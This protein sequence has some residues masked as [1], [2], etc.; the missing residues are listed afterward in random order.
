MAP[1]L[2][3]TPPGVAAA[4]PRTKYPTSQSGWALPRHAAEL[5]FASFPV[6]SSMMC[7]H[8]SSHSLSM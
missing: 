1:V 6:V 2:G 4:S 8:F 5:T 3:G 7:L